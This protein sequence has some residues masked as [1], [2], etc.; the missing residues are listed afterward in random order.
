MKNTFEG[1]NGTLANRTGS[2]TS[3]NQPIRTAE[4][5]K[6]V[7]KMRMGSSK[8]V[9]TMKKATAEDVNVTF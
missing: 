3:G 2:V 5:K 8:V 4:R 1:T 6:N 7:K 9:T